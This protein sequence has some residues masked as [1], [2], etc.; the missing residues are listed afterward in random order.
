MPD[1]GGPAREILQSLTGICDSSKPY[2]LV[3]SSLW[4]FLVGLSIWH[5]V[6]NWFPNIADQ[7]PVAW[8]HFHVWLGVP[9]GFTCKYGVLPIYQMAVIISQSLLDRSINPDALGQHI[10]ISSLWAFTKLLAGYISTPVT[11][12]ISFI[13]LIG[14]YLLAVPL[15]CLSEIGWILQGLHPY[16]LIVEKTGSPLLEGD[17]VDS[18]DVNLADESSDSSKSSSYSTYF[19]E[20]ATDPWSDDVIKVRVDDQPISDD[21]IPGD[22]VVHRPIHSWDLFPMIV[23]SPLMLSRVI[24]YSASVG[25]LIYVGARAYLALQGVMS[26]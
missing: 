26:L 14:S 18:A 12:F 4:S 11:G 23:W 17:L 7:F 25:S 8:Y 15:T 1:I 9:I 16:D 6:P 21:E 13:K 2:L 24:R 10:W 20:V 19:K 5:D 3:S 22:R